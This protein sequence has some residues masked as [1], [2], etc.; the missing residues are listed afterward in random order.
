[1][2]SLL[3]TLFMTPEFRSKLY[4]WTYEPD[5]HGLPEDCIPLQLQ[6]LFAR[7]HL[8]HSTL[9]T[10]G[11][12][13]S[14][15]WNEGES[16]QQHDAQEFCRVLFDAI[17]I[18]VSGTSLSEMIRELF[19][20]Q[21][22]SYVKC[23]TCDHESCMTDFFLDWSLTVRNPFEGICNGSVEEALENYLKAEILSGDNQYFCCNCEAKRDAA[24]GFRITR[25]PYILSLQLKRF[26]LDYNTFERVKLNDVVKFPFVLNLNPFVYGGDKTQFYLPQAEHKPD[27]GLNA[28]DL[29]AASIADNQAKSQVS[30][31]TSNGK[32]DEFEDEEIKK[33]TV[34][35]AALESK[36]GGEHVYD[37]Y[38]VLVH[39]GSAFSGHYY[40][41]IKSFENGNWYEFNDTLVRRISYDKV[42][43][44]FGKPEHT[45]SKNSTNA[46][47]LL[48]RKVTDETISEVPQSTI[49]E[50]LD[51]L[52]KLQ[53]EE[54]AKQQEEL[55]A[56]IEEQK[57]WQVEYVEIS[58][59]LKLYFNDPTAPQHCIG[60]F[61]YK[62]S[63]TIKKT[64]S[65]LR[66]KQKIGEKLG[67]APEIFVMKLGNKYSPEIIPSD[68]S[69]MDGGITC[70][71]VLHLDPDPTLVPKK[72]RLKL[73]TG[74]YA[75]PS[76]NDAVFDRFDL[77][78]CV[79]I[80]NYMTVETV[81]QTALEQIGKDCPHVVLRPDALQL[82]EAFGNSLGKRLE[83]PM[84]MESYSLWDEKAYLLQDD[85]L[86]LK[87]F[88]IHIVVKR[89]FPAKWDLSPSKFIKV[90]KTTLMSELGRLIEESFDIPFDNQEVC[91]SEEAF[92]FSRYDLTRATWHRLSQQHSSIYAGP[93]LIS[94]D[95]TIVIVKDST[96]AER[97][98]TVE[99]RKLHQQQALT[100]TTVPIGPYKPKEK[101]VKIRVKNRTEAE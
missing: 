48:Y 93:L 35:Q 50:Y 96:E 40:S 18:S 19:Q 16:F 30:N 83:D 10:A 38:A 45:E 66:L 88:D 69:V 36:Q 43:K 17:D 26:D 52:I 67:L 98:L 13:K 42:V 33:L 86:D 91:S 59:K 101:A 94:K 87:E 61:D 74:I 58:N 25:L 99:E 21:L 79:D 11:L 77:L 63:V 68:Q 73:F 28:S 5:R 7:L 46:Y 20:S 76:V 65:T 12:T 27:N 62:F 64:K 49:P 24:K 100:M 84:R 90:Q 85:P 82:R 34:A 53:Q 72:Y 80:L 29:D 54:E 97:P 22:T 57:K 6:L 3:Q 95:F 39:S 44:A 55:L 71:T 14:F 51:E 75:D 89:F 92:K 8:S 15:G 78:T 41:Y 81:K 2:N 56:R 31:G 37:L 4:Q 70:N 32:H 23:L 1:M 47:M 60:N 9:R